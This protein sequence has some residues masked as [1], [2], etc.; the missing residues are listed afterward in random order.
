M[1]EVYRFKVAA[2]QSHNRAF[3]KTGGHIDPKLYEFDV[4]LAPTGKPISEQFIRINHTNSFRVECCRT[5]KQS[6]NKMRRS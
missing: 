4:L 5:R 6:R 3:D 1:K 2:D